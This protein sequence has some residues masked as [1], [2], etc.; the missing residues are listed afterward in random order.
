[1]KTAQT[2]DAGESAF[3]HA[4]IIR[5]LV[6][7]KPFGS[8]EGY[9]FIVDNG[10]SLMRVQVKAAVITKVG[11]APSYGDNNSGNVEDFK[12][13]IDVLALYNLTTHTFYFIPSKD[14]VRTKITIG[15]ASKYD[16]FKDKW[17]VF[18]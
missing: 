6:V 5:G 1:M 17:S 12:R 14:I 7:C 16:I 9:D 15:A 18:D 4:A 13:N 3:L 10:K 11:R 8:A 2:G